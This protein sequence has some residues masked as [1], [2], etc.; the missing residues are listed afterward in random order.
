MERV[1]PLFGFLFG[2]PLAA[3]SVAVGVVS[4]PIIIHLL[5]RK[6]FRIV[7]WAAMRFLLAAQRENTRRLRVEQLLLLAVR[8]LLVLL[9]ILAMA[10][11]MPWAETVWRTLFPE[12]VALAGA[13]STQRTHKILVLDGSFSMAVK[14]GDTNYFGRAKTLAD[15]IIRGST[16]GDG[17]SVVLMSAPPRRIVPEPSEDLSKVAAEV[18]ALKLPHGNA[19]LAGT[20][21]TVEGLL[22]SSPGK[23][24]AKEVYF[25]TDMQQSTWISGG[26]VGQ[27]SSLSHAMLQK[28]QAKARTIFVDVGDEHTN[29]VAVTSLTLGSS[30]ATTGAAT[31]I[32]ATIHN[33]GRETREQ[34]GVKLFVGRARSQAAD[35]PFE[36]R[37]VNQNTLKLARGQNVVSFPYRFSVAG[38]YVV[39]VAVDNDA[40]ELDDTRSAVVTVKNTVPVLLINGKPATDPFDRGTE[41]L[42]LALNPFDGA[43]VPGSLPARPKVLNESQFADAGLG[44]LTPFDCVCLCDVARL[45]PP[46]VHR[47][48]MHLRSGGGVVFFVGDQVDLGSYNELLYKNGNGLLPGRLLGKQH[49]SD[50]QFFHFGVVDQA[51]VQPP[52]DAFS[53][54]NDRASLLSARFR[55]YMRTELAQRGQPRKV[56]TYLPGSVQGRTPTGPESASLPAGDPALVEWQPLLPSLP[57]ENGQ[58]RMSR[59]RGRVVLFTTTANM[60]WTSW[61]A[62]PSFLP[63][64]QEVLRF[65]VSGR[66]REQAA[67]VGDVLDEYLPTSGTGLEATIFLPDGQKDTART[68]TFEDAS[69][70]RWANTDLSGV[71]RITVG[72][73]PQDHLFAVNVPAATEAQQASE[74]D[75]TRTNGDELHKAYPDWEVQIV[76]DP[77]DVVHLPA[78]GQPGDAPSAPLGPTVAQWLLQIVFVLL[79]LEVVLA[80]RFGHHSAIAGTVENATRTRGPVGKAWSAVWPRVLAV[81]LVFLIIALG[82]FWLGWSGLGHLLDYLPDSMSETIEAGMGVP[83]PAPGEGRHWEMGHLPLSGL[84]NGSVDP[85]VVAFLALAGGTLVIWIYLLEGRT[86]ALR[87]RLLFALLRTGL[88][89]LTLFVLWPQLRLLFERQSWPDVAILVDDSQ[90][91]SA[92]DRYR[93]ADVRAV[94]DMLLRDAPALREEKERLAADLEKQAR[95]KEEQAAAARGPEETKT[96][97]DAATALRQQAVVLRN[98]A[99]RLQG[100]RDSSQLQRL[101]LVQLLLGRKDLDWLQTLLSERRVRLHIYHCSTRAARLADATDAKDIGAAR[102]AVLS[103]RADA[104]HDSSQL[105]AAVRQVLND[106][107][108]SSL[109][110]VVMLTD[111]VTTEG[112]DLVKVSRYASQVGVPLYL[113]GV[114]DHHEARDL[115]LHDLHVEEN[116]YVNDTIVFEVRLTA[117]GYPGMTIPVRLREKGKDKVLKEEK[118]T[119]DSTGKPAKVRILYKPTEPGEKQFVID[120]PVQAD[121]VN[122]DN[123]V[124]E[125]AI[126]V[127]QAKLIR[128][129]YVEGYARYEYRFIKTLLERESARVKGNKTID[130]K[131]LLL[132]AE[133]AYAEQDKSALADFPTKAELNQVDVIVLGDFDPRDDTRT[134]M[135]ENLKNI[136]E[137]VKE[138][139][140]GVLMIAG[141][142]WSP[143]AF[144]DTPLA[145][146]LPIDLTTDRQPEEPPM[147][148]PVGFRPEL[149]PVGRMH[150]IFRFSPDE[151]E[152]EDIWKH[153][154][155]MFWWSEGYVPKRA[156]EILAVL[157]KQEAAKSAVLNGHPLAVQQFVGAGRSL[158]FGFNESWRWRFREDEL[159]FNQFWV[160]TMRYLARS[161]QGRT[162]LRL[163]RQTPYRRGEPI[164]VT[165]RFPDDAAPP[166]D[167]TDVKVVVERKPPKTGGAAEPEVQTI[168]LAKMDG[169]RGTFE[170]LLTRTPEGDYNFWLSAPSVD[171]PKP[172]AEG[173]VLA[174]PGEME[175][176]QMNRADLERAAE[177]SHGRFYTLADADN[178]LRDLPTGNRITLNLPTPPYLLWNHALVFVLAISLLTLEWVL[179]KSR[180]LL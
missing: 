155:E 157:P 65:S 74:S 37:L 80:W 16:G 77:K 39:Q 164:R 1:L 9:L 70:L 116:V 150:P 81:G 47:L 152:S 45:S 7:T 99:Q 148:R 58:A 78:P 36:M 134:K 34:V 21:A 167:G 136:A 100:V 55:D 156:A 126:T 67:T 111:G 104:S 145:D 170:G 27:A 96:A 85:W 125:R 41:W 86:A 102:Q 146:V 61:P 138:K 2:T 76:R 113:I 135:S 169:S 130:L 66:L 142:R 35:P 50:G 97:R 22:Q 26:T 14:A 172:R 4:I 59:A 6:R 75:L 180:H 114:G 153:L 108:G 177:E 24:S 120:V 159:R 90:S 63:M 144:K 44:D 92:N 49:A 40:L 42:R 154:R 69:I 15:K 179:R 175:R 149:T 139:G 91:Q 103:L 171:G 101:D 29:N 46:E 32:T 162:E 12:S 30:L 109:S 119:V 143:H 160:Q 57:D 121:E 95:A 132:D 31:P 87:D 28:I 83:P 112:E 38:D 19:D 174:P 117:H 137:F 94:A 131:V 161:R 140:G 173:K 84:W 165:V 89:L 54:D 51:Y 118:V 168:Q 11:V 115:H 10:S 43:S 88:L 106:F 107:R 56:L 25:L 124:V 71:Y 151:K 20:L 166:A 147:G 33:Y 64:M 79:L 110:A 176:L 163:D 73:H 178:L 127:Q 141:D 133:P 5:N 23:F 123:N 13:N 53:D 62:S 105:G 8:S 68:Q 129:L 128:V 60:D 122:K 52:L 48:E 3:V 158:F 82:A 17:L 98:E 72:Q 18:Q 93:D